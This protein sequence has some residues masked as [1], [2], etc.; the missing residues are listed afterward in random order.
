MS[1]FGDSPKWRRYEYPEHKFDY[2]NVDDYVY[3]SVGRR[4]KYVGL[5]A[6]LVKDVFVYGM[7][8][9]IV[10]LRFFPEIKSILAFDPD[11]PRGDSASVS[12]VGECDSILP[13]EVARI[14]NWLVLASV[15]VSY[16]LMATDLFKAKRVIISRD[17]ALAYVDTVAYRAYCLHSYSY[18]CFF[19]MLANW[20][21][22][23]DYLA[24]YVLFA[25]KGWKRLFLAEACRHLLNFCALVDLFRVHRFRHGR[26][27]K[28]VE[29]L[30]FLGKN[31]LAQTVVVVFAT[32]TIFV[33]LIRVLLIALAGLL[34]IPFLCY[35]IRGNLK[36]YCCT[37]ID[38]R[39]TSLLREVERRKALLSPPIR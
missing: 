35:E 15:S 9:G 20:D 37:V 33:F 26:D 2:I 4:L 18:F 24:F 10:V 39:M 25:L 16:M 29:L 38:K 27:F 8:L 6:S 21:R 5:F 22:L 19:Q 31:Q 1:C 13:D 7:E 34:Y 3:Y 23:R 30:Q 36:E 11:I 12:T 32:F 28:Y 17:I 14:S